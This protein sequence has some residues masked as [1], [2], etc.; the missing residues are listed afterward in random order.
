MCLTAATSWAQPSAGAF[1]WTAPT[2]FV[3]ERETAANAAP[4]IPGARVT[5]TRTNGA[6]GRVLIDYT[7]TPGTASPGADYLTRSGTLVFDDFQMSASIVVPIVDDF[8]TPNASR[9]FAVNLSNVRLDPAE[10]A[11]IDPPT[12]AASSATVVIRDLDTDA[13]GTFAPFIFNFEKAEYRVVEGSGV[14]TVFVRR[15]GT[16]NVTASVD[17]STLAGG[18]PLQAGSDYAATPA[19]FIS[20]ST[21]LTF[22]GNGLQAFDIPIVDDNR[23][24]FNEDFFVT[25]SR[26]VGADPLDNKIG[27]NGTCT[28]TILS[29]DPVAGAVD[30][31]WNPD[32]LLT[33]DP[34]NV[35]APG[36]NG[37]VYSLLIQT[38][39]T[40][41][42][43][44]DF[45]AYNGIADLG[46]GNFL[47]HIARI[48]AN[49]S[50]DTTFTPGSGADGFITT[51][52]PGPNGSTIIGG[53]FTA[54][55]G[56]Q[57]SSIAQINPDGSLDTSFNPGL[58]AD[59]T[60]WTV[61]PVGNQV[62][63]GGEF[64]H[65][66]GAPRNYIARLNPD[67]SLDDT[68]D[69]GSNL[70]GPVFALGVKHGA[71][72]LDRT[73]TGDDQEDR[74]VI[75]TGGNAGTITINYDFLSVPD[76]MRIYYDN[77][78]IYDSGYTNGTKTVVIPYGPGASTSIT[79]VMNEGG[80]TPGTAWLYTASISTTS[81]DQIFI[82]GGFTA[83]GGTSRNGVARLLGT[84][85]L[86]TTFNPGAGCDGTV[87]SLAVQPDGKTL[88]GGDFDNVDLRSHKAVARL[89]VDGSLDT[90]F[91][92]GSGPNDVVYSLSLQADG[93][94]Y[95]GGLFTAVNGTRRVG[96]TRLFADGPVDTSF[97]D[98]AYNQFAGIVNTNFSQPPNFVFATTIT[99]NSD[100]L[101]GGGFR[102]LGGDSAAGRHPEL[103]SLGVHPRR[104]VAQLL[105]GS[106]PGPGNLQFAK[107]TYSGNEGTALFITLTRANGNLGPASATFET[108]DLPP[109]PGAAQEGVDYS[110]DNNTY[111]QP[112]WV[113]RAGAF[114][115][116]D[117]YTGPNNLTASTRDDVYIQLLNTPP[118]DGTRSFDL[119]LSAPKGIDFLF[120][121]GENT[122]LGLALGKADATVSI[123][124]NGSLPGTLSF[125]SPTYTVNENG[126]AANVTVTRTGGSSGLVTV[127]CATIL[128]GSAD[129][130]IDYTPRARTLTFPSGVTN[131]TF[132]FFITDDSEVEGDETVLLQLSNP[133]GGA[134]LG[135]S[136][137]T[138]TII[139]NDFAPGRLNFTAANFNVYENAGT[140]VVTVARNGGS[141][142]AVTVQVA[143]S[144]GTATSGDYVGVT[145][146]LSWNS[147]ETG[148]KNIYIPIIN[149]GI[150]ESNETINVTLLNAT[151]AGTNS[152][153]ALG[154]V[155][156]ATLTIVDDDF[157][158]TVQFSSD[159]Y[160]F[161]ENGGPAVVTVVRTDGSAESIT[162]NFS[163]GDDTA[164][165][166]TDYLG[167]NGTLSFGP[168][169]VSK[170]FSVPIINNSVSNVPRSLTLTLANASPPGTLGF[171]DVATLNIIDDESFNEPPGTLDTAYDPA[172]GMNGAIQ[173]LTLQS[174]GSLVVAG[175]FSQANGLARGHVARLFD[176]GSLDTQ[177]LSVGAGANGSVRA[178][179]SQSDDR[180]LIG[181]VFTAYNGVPRSS[182]ARLNFNGSLDSIFDPG[183]GADNP[184]FAI[185]ESFNDT[186]RLILVGGSF[187]T[188]KGTPRNRIARLLDNGS[189]DLTFDPG[190][191]ANGT[192]YAIVAYPTNGL[193]GGKCL[194]GGDFTS[195][196]GTACG[197]IA[198][199]NTDGSVDQTFTAG[200]G[201]NDSVRAISLQADGR[202]LLGG[203]FTN[204][205]GA[206]LNHI[207]RLNA[208]GTLDATFNPGS[209]ADG[210]VY[211]IAVQPDTRI[212]LGGEFARYNGVTRNHITRLNLDGSVDPTINFGYGANNY[213][214]GLSVQADDFIVLGGGF[215]TYDNVPRQYLARAYGRSVA[216]SGTFEFSSTAF[217]ANESASN[218]VVTIRR[219]GGSSSPTNS[220]NVVVTFTATDITATN[221]VNY[222]GGTFTNTFG[223]GETLQNTLIPLRRD[224][225]ITP[226][227]TVNLVIQDIQ[228]LGLTNAI[229]AKPQAT[230]YIT[231]VDSGIS[232]PS[233]TYSR[234]EN[235][236]DGRATIS[237][238]RSGS[239]SGSA[240][241]T[242]MTTTNG[243]AAPFLR[244]TPV[245]TNVIF[246][247]GQSIQN[248]YIP[249]TNDNIAEGD[250]TVTMALSA[251]S[252]SFLV[253][254]G[255]ATLT[256]VDDD[257]SPG[258]LQFSA[259]N[260]IVSER[261]TNAVLTVNRI[262]G[263]S[264]KVSVDYFTQDG[265]AITGQKYQ[266]TNGTLLFAEGESVKTITVPIL[267]ENLVEGN[268][269]FSAFLTNVAGGATIGTNSFA[270]VTI[271][272][273]D[274]GISFSS[275]AYVISETN[276]QITLT[277]L[278]SFGTNAVTRV[279]YAT[280]NGTAVANINYTNV[281]GTLTFN[282][283][284]V[285]KTLT[286]PLKHDPSVTGNLLFGVNLFNATNLTGQSSAQVSFPGS[287]SVILLDGETGLS[288]TNSALSVLENST[289]AVI[290]IVCSN[291]NV[292]AVSVSY[293]TSDGTAQ[294]GLD[295]LAVSN[296]ITFAN[297]LT[298]TNIS[299]PIIDNLSVDGDRTF[300]VNLLAPSPTNVAQ[301][302]SPSSLT[303][304]I[305]DNDAGLSFSSP[306]YS[307]LKSGVTATI[308]VLRTSFTN[309][310]VSVNYSTQ[311][312][313]ATNGV[314]YFGTS[315]T[316]TFT[317]GETSKSFA[318][319][320]IDST[321]IK[322]DRTVQLILSNVVG[323][324]S[325]IFPSNATL[326]IQ[327]NTGSL[328]VPAGVAL[329]SEANAGPPNGVID[330]G[331]RVGL[332][333]AFRNIA[334]T[335]TTNLVAT[336]LTNANVSSP[337]GTNGSATNIYGVLAAGGP[338]V[339]R[340]FSFTANGTNGQTITA[341]IWLQDGSANR[342]TNDFAFVLGNNSTTFSNN[343]VI[344]INDNTNASPYPSTLN[345][346]G[347]G[348]SL[349]K[350]T[351]GFNR[352]Y[353]TA[354]SD[355]DALLVSPAGQKTLLM[356][357]AG[358]SSGN[359]LNN[360]NL[361][362]DDAAATFLP[363]FS[364]ITVFTNKPTSYG[365][366]PSFPVPAPPPPFTT[367]LTAF[368]GSN[369][370]GTWFL[371]VLDDTPLDS[372]AI[373]NGWSLSF[374]TANPVVGS[375][376]LALSLTNLPNP[377]VVGSN[378]TYTIS[379]TN[380]GPATATNV[381]LTDFWPAN[382][383]FVSASG[384]GFVTN[385]N[386]ISFTNLGA[387]AKD[388]FVNLTVVLRPNAVGLLT[389][390]AIASSSSLD[391]NLANNTRTTSASVVNPSA[392]LLLTMVD[393]PNPVTVGNLLTYTNTVFNLGIATATSVKMTNTLPPSVTFVSAS[394]AT[395]V[396]NGSV[397]AFTNLGNILSGGQV[398]ATI[399][400]TPNLP[401]T[402]TNSAS[403]SS[404]VLD[405][406]KP[407][408]FASV[409]TVV[410]PLPMSLT[411]IGN[412]LTL[413]WPTNGTA[414]YILESTPSLRPPVL[415]SPETN[416]APQL[417]GDQRGFT[418]YTTNA[419]KFFRLRAPAP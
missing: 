256:I 11:A 390:T 159:E 389:N 324:A 382:A 273:D 64:T 135:L 262:G 31:S 319:N 326:T 327:D 47:N 306:A 369:P 90:S 128:G 394:P 154:T 350:V 1:T 116:S 233:S 416:S 227:L 303:V 264:G 166:G 419:S 377:V 42:A 124:D 175:D 347:L 296:T 407:N 336:L 364:Q 244:Y 118:G 276:S 251:P 344:V 126:V 266:S 221:G 87:Y 305:L 48:N 156:N 65:V 122:P 101:I 4:S 204:V 258:I 282:P 384:G 323:N 410:Q 78:R 35:A 190:I 243:T 192:V 293:A 355:I 170:T 207:A 161:N 329:L 119:Q 308:G 15:T 104:N 117:A 334:G 330:P 301:L 16:S 76:E 285:L 299:I 275:P 261:A 39:N 237:I 246:N 49:G 111:G 184:I 383:T 354:P 127:N 108:I 317:N 79:I 2:Y 417:Y 169:E 38:N 41:L 328:I 365:P 391:P 68:F 37:V 226:D 209:G 341:R 165:A 43:A 99:S 242:F 403:V 351:V 408:N 378:L 349:S 409:K 393:V 133:T 362:F 413:L 70:N 234:S 180:I 311:D 348:A 6:S 401:G 176:D 269:F 376:D 189:V 139:D 55:N 168:G 199:L 34:P 247:A 56:Q 171:N 290:T 186:N 12:I 406:F 58:G 197:H 60:V 193:F 320:V 216:G 200:V 8:R 115:L 72:T 155:T 152:P 105:G 203:L 191:G 33:T 238:L 25:L 7:T 182:I 153:G 144:D 398:V 110:F 380:Y 414:G 291:P 194:I 44:G 228:P 73:A 241:V 338:S 211:S 294:A 28:V 195:V 138:V 287:A 217:G 185:G 50:L 14:V 225:I 402:I 81:G 366:V 145:N 63:I 335:S 274:S 368:N 66:N 62:I 143:T 367:N 67:G 411:H 250:Q 134:S 379:L 18:L 337:V 236:I 386:F 91:D 141:I 82:G 281:S 314:D 125:S 129:E 249:L 89:N 342:G 181:G 107:A 387:L 302:V 151:V 71:I 248:V 381:S 150:V 120:L 146:T 198:R 202:I 100:V 331:E 187:T 298:S 164:F 162:V 232:F 271:L 309:S 412:N 252:N 137:A 332:Y 278:R 95:A 121:G 255:T 201:A 359:P 259:T 210:A 220:A 123:I 183:S 385:N 9:Q 277:V 316:L 313:T 131:A 392:D 102:I 295:Y 109:G 54:Y 32:N 177:F 206:N 363:Q 140:G 208:N 218:A 405:P 361:S 400:V 149:D 280:T 375:A 132:S 215:T 397:L 223:P 253:N 172:A 373:S 86:D 372:G 21:N 371:Y 85:A 113:R 106:T 142:G 343:A 229:G 270:T 178:V 23:A 36:A 321:T 272:D 370:N 388:A 263:A 51:M 340:A 27:A 240:Q 222:I 292:G 92:A 213:V 318:F 179:L 395:Y 267:D 45:T 158:G 20:T 148:P 219:R 418:V 286:I 53:G 17:I 98:T 352:L 173:A 396:L 357:N 358:G 83:Y 13:T 212:L 136:D 29:D 157:R 10:T 289:N 345:V 231:N 230:L 239:T 26:P 112:T 312:G 322:P 399:S 245:V 279:N 167:T 196:A 300:T 30:T 188:I 160:N 84:G 346:S 69:P 22:A 288:F 174:D 103:E 257:S 80:G 96:L 46:G 304:T 130:G 40:I 353:H 205:A 94:I 61:L 374:V 283:G 77:I 254:P 75:D 310:T 360:A 97:M 268:L 52:A 415:W 297:G 325:L 356:A 163:T 284:E 235:A 88:I 265:T 74:V 19:D 93:T 224:F 57:R 307:I 3:T 114:A 24:E 147:G 59:G 339:S 315:G 5:V 260:Y 333:F 404:P 214:A